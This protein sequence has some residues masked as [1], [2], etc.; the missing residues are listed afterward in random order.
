MKPTTVVDQ[1]RIELAR[2]R[3]RAHFAGLLIDAVM[4]I[5]RQRAALPGFEIHQVIAHRAAIQRQ[6]RFIRLLQQRQ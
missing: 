2:D 4:G 1:Q 6:R 5:R 3:V